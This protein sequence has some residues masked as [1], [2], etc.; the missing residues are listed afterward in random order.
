VQTEYSLFIWTGNTAWIDRVDD[1]MIW[2]RALR[3]DGG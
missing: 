3:D 2:T 1:V